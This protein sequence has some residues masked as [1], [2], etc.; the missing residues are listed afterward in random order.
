M[1]NFFFNEK[2][3]KTK[4]GA[5]SVLSRAVRMSMNSSLKAVS[6][7]AS[8][9]S[10]STGIPFALEWLPAGINMVKAGVSNEP[11]NGE[12]NSIL[13]SNLAHED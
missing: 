3:S 10:S 11:Y 7:L 9:S 1:L 2:A 6:P 12:N 13:E 5:A 4:A 8:I